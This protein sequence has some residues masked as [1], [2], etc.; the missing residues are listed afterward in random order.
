MLYRVFTSRRL[1]GVAAARLADPAEPETPALPLCQSVSVKAACIPVCPPLSFYER[2]EHSFAA[3]EDG[4]IWGFILAQSVWQGDKPIVLIRTLSVAP[5]SLPE[6]TLGL[7]HATT[8]SAY[9]AAVYE[10]HFPLLPHLEQAGQQD[11]IFALG[12]YAVRHL[13][14]RAATAAGQRLLKQEEGK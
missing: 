8:K 5:E 12:Q 2:S 11:G 10:L 6:I 13:G 1:F 7:F 9:D 4:K 3:E 14:T